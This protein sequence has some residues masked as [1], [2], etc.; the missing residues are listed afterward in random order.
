MTDLEAITAMLKRAMVL[1]TFH[2]SELFV[3][4]GYP[5]FYCMFTFHEDGSLKDLEAFD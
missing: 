1:Y 5:G 2:D 4:R 3:E